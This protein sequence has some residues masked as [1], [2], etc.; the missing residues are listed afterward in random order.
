[1][2][3]C[4]PKFNAQ[5][6]IDALKSGKID[7]EKLITMSSDERRAFLEPIVGEDNVREVNAQ[8]E[9]KLLLKDQKTGLVSWAKKIS[10]ITEAT[11]TDIL[12]KINRMTNVL[13]A[14]N[15]NA[16]LADLAAKRLGTDVSYDEAQSIVKGSQTLAEAKSSYDPSKISSDIKNN[17][18]KEYPGWTSD[19]AAYDYGVKY[20][21]FQKY[22]ATLKSPTAG[23]ILEA[24]LKNPVKGLITVSN[25]VKGLNATLDNSFFGRQGLR[26]LFTDPEVWGDAFVKS[27]GTA[28][29]ALL[30]TEGDIDPVD[31]VKAGIVPRENAMNGNYSRMRIAGIANAI[32]GEEALPSRIPEK[33]PVLGRV[34]A[35]SKDAFDASALR[36]RADLADKIIK[37]YT[38]GG[39]DFSDPDQAKQAGA[40]IN[41]MTG[42]GDIGRLQVIGNEINAVAFSIKFLK[43]NFDTLFQGLKAV[44]EMAFDK[45]TGTERT[46]VE[47][48]N[49]QRAATNL[50]KVV[51][52]MSALLATANALSP[53]SAEL[54]PRSSNFGKIKV[55]THTI[56]ISGGLGSIITLAARIT[57]TKHGDTG[58][59]FGHGISFWTKSAAGKYTDLTAGKYGQQ[60][61]WDV[62]NDFWTGKLSP[63][64][65]VVHDLLTGQTYQNTKPTFGN[66]AQNLLAPIPL[67]TFEQL[68]E[69]DNAT[70]LGAMIASE[71]GFSV[72]T[73]PTKK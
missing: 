35:A 7:P 15:E 37:S 33:V 10:G 52:G 16:F 11:R 13:D 56:D 70:A 47:I 2:A 58:G 3:F 72:S 54:D 6:F 65:G 29:D 38:A 44:P 32:D 14:S 64:L 66:E 9:S 21:E 69:P 42:R 46:P 49:R 17:P 39:V 50:A 62:I 20:T 61:G 12:S 55:G 22:I 40:M 24:N 57:P 59:E 36:M 68:K 4:L 30:K 41:S 27:F 53:G 18:D 43:S 51:L 63:A 25:I 8:L 31:A 45:I 71:L 67:Q 23:D 73:T 60:N 34:Y 1:M 19:D 5:K 48:M 26:T 28:K